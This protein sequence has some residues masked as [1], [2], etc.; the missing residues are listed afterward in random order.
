MHPTRSKNNDELSFIFK[1][2]MELVGTRLFV[3]IFV[4]TL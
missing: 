3:G 1:S 2:L 4:M